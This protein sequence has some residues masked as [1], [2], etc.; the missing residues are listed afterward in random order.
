MYIEAF[1]NWNQ[2]VKKVLHKMSI[3]IQDSMIGHIQNAMFR[4]EAWDI[5]VQMFANKYKSQEDSAKQ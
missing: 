2:G 1:K 5:L 3:S 4:K